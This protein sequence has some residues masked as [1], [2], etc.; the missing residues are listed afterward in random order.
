MSGASS[1]LQ[2]VTG[3]IGGGEL[4][5]MEHVASF[6]DVAKSLGAT[7]ALDG[8]DMRIREGEIHALLGPNGAGKTTAF[9]LLLG[10]RHPDS[11]TVTL[12]GGN[13]RNPTT[14]GGVGATPQ[15]PAF[16]EKLRVAEVL[17]FVRAYFPDTWPTAELLDR[18]GLTDLARRETGGLSGG[19]KRRL[20]V[21]VA[22]AGKP[23]L[24]VLDEPTTGLD[25][26]VRRAVWHAVREY[27]RAGGTVLLTTHYLEE[28]EALADRVTLIHRGAAVVTGTVGEVTAK[29]RGAASASLE[30][31][32]LALTRGSL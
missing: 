24:A 2:D 20:A 11:G 23:W 7:R 8:F 25:V 9:G 18:F 21:A 22:F 27:V 13:P 3:V 19:E 6:D 31:A 14:R 26:E 10:L 4:A 17:D 12:L 5:E 28:A 29:V 16:P 30:A 1:R 15:E 32:F